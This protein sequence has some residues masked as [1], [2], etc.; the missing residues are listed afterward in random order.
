MGPAYQL[1]VT[2]TQEQSLSVTGF[3]LTLALSLVA[4]SGT[5]Q[6]LQVILLPQC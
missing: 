1:S 2:S 5:A 4:N 6:L 3:L